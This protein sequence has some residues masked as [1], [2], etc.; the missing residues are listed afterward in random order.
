MPRLKT[1]YLCQECGYKAPKWMGQCTGCQAWN[2]LVEEV[3][4]AVSIALKGRAARAFM[5]VPTSRR[6]P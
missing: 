6:K 5:L 3:E 4:E 1:V 2:S